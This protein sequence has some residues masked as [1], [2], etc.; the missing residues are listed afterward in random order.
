MATTKFQCFKE[1]LGYFSDCFKGFKVMKPELE[2]L[3]RKE[4]LNFEL[5]CSSFFPIGF[6][7]KAVWERKHP[8]SSSHSTTK[9]NLSV[10]LADLR[11]VSGLL[12]LGVAGVAIHKTLSSSSSHKDQAKLSYDHGK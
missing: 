8:L 4:K 11:T 5:N 1:M 3:T 10:S 2:N 6:L 7:H 9:F 12:A